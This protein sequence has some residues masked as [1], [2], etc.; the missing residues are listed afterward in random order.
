MVVKMSKLLNEVPGFSWVTEPREDGYAKCSA[1][2]ESFWL[3]GCEHKDGQ[4]WIG[5]VDNELVCTEDH[6]LKYG[7]VVWFVPNWKANDGH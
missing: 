5:T 7:D 4:R 1:G 2:G 3:K 6:G